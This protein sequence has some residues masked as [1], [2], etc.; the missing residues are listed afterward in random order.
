MIQYIF[1]ILILIGIYGLLTQKNLIKLV[2]A[3]NVLEVGV[4]LFII[5]V[6]YVN[7]GVAPILFN[8]VK[9]TNSLFVDPLPQALVLTAIVIG[10]GVT[11]LALTVV[12]KLYAKY[13]TLE[14]DEM[15]SESND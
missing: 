8:G 13:G 9:T 6:G 2:V 5:S 4:N 11:A 7:D 3:L 10:V 12:R 14:L 1:I 15:G